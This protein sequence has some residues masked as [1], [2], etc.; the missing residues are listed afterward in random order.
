MLA[1]AWFLKSMLDNA[2][3]YH[4]KTTIVAAKT[5]N[6]VIVFVQG[7]FCERR[8]KGARRIR[9]TVHE[10]QGNCNLLL[11]AFGN[12]FSKY[13]AFAFPETLQ[14]TQQTRRDT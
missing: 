12:R 11:I 7:D 10:T 3:K 5:T 9:K 6:N 14:G 2:R 13:E 4:A 1:A 8:S